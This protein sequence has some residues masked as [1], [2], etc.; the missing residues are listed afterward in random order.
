MTV[1]NPNFSTSGWLI[2]ARSC[3]PWLAFATLLA[4][5]WRVSDP[6]HNIPAYGD[7]LEVIWGIEWY[8][9]ALFVQR[10]S[11]FFDSLVFHPN[12]WHTVSLA[13]TPLL[14]FLGSLLFAIGGSSALAYNLLALG[15]T[16]VAFQG[17]RRFVRNYAGEFATTVA[18]LVFT[19]MSARWAKVGG[20][21]HVLFVTSLF[22]WFV[23]SLLN[24]LALPADAPRR[25]V[26]RQVI[27]CG[28]CWGVMIH[29]SLYSLF[30]GAIGFAIGGWRWIGERRV[31]Q[32]MAIGVVALL[33][34]SP[35]LMLYVQAIQ[36]EVPEKQGI[37]IHLGMWSASL[38]SFFLPSIDHPLPIVRQ[39][40]RA[41]YAG[42]VDESG[43]M[44]LGTI[45]WGLTGVGLWRTWRAE[46]RQATGKQ[47]RGLLWLVV[48]ALILALGVLLRWHGIFLQTALFEPLN[49]SLWQI[50]RWLKPD[51]FD[52]VQLD[53]FFA[54]GVPLPGLLLAILVPFWDSARTLSRYALAAGLGL[55]GLAALGMQRLSMP[56]RLIM[57]LLWLIESLP[58]QTGNIALP[59]QPHSA[60][61]WIA[62][63]PRLPGEGIIDLR[64]D[65][66][67]MTWGEIVYATRF[68]HVPTV[69]GVGSFSP[70]HFA[71]MQDWLRTPNAYSQPQTAYLFLQYGARYALFH[72]MSETDWGNWEQLRKNP[73]L[74]EVA[75]FEPSTTV[76][77]WPYPIC[78]VEVLPPPLWPK[79]NLWRQEGWSGE[80]EWGL[81]AEGRQS[82]AQWV[83][84][85]VRDQQ[86]TINAFPYCPANQPQSISI[87]VNGQQVGEHQWQ[88]CEE[89]Q[90]A[91]TIPAT[92]VN[93]GWNQIEFRYGY[94]NQP[95]DTNGAPTDARRLAVGFS[96]IHIQ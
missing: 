57:A 69:S 46:R 70:R 40:A 49:Q 38:D 10:V 36:A 71:A 80:E 67:Q 56:L 53:T 43:L 48:L 58:V 90:D 74:R 11:P 77:P 41:L 1:P 65:P 3:M 55:V 86:L 59:T 32:V 76:S 17:A 91:V 12:G 7:A 47:A 87:W 63:Q 4:F 64:S 13:H 29:F 66:S 82:T 88:A 85:Q 89:W 96:R 83:A 54:Q 52:T 81:W 15:S 79:L 18:A 25:V 84:T 50:G 20:H 44:N 8:H 16:L 62:N 68:H 24:L 39:V 28:L 72:V 26:W 75:C 33:V 92:L 22:P 37:L 14:F 45:T 94:A 78:I 21:F 60:Y 31:L 61:A 5:G 73:L 30:F 2:R 35:L 19:F 6:L 27:I 93:L 9:E 42:P 95:V 23:W 51:L 34:A